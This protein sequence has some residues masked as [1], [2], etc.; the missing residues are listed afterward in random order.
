M[1][2]ALAVAAAPDRTAPDEAKP[3]PPADA[4]PRLTIRLAPADAPSARLDDLESITPVY[5]SDAP[6]PVARPASALASAAAPVPVGERVTLWVRNAAV[7]GASNVTNGFER[8]YQGKYINR[9]AELSVPFSTL[10]T[11]THTIQPGN[12]R[13]TA[14]AERRISTDDPEIVIA[15]SNMTVKVYAIDILA[16]RGDEGGPPESR[17]EPESFGLYVAPNPQTPEK[18]GANL[19]TRSGAFYS[20]R[21]YLPA[22][23]DGAGYILYPYGQT[24][25]VRPGGSVELTGDKLPGITTEGSRIV[26]EYSV[27]QGRVVTRTGLSA[28]LGGA[29]VRGNTFVLRPS[30][31]PLRFSAGQGLNSLAFGLPVDSDLT[32]RPRKYF[33]ADNTGER[34]AD[35]RIMA[36]E[37]DNDALTAGATAAVSVRFADNWCDFRMEDVVEPP[38][39]PAA[40]NAPAAD[41]ANETE[42]ATNGWR[43]ILTALQQHH[44]ASAPRHPFSEL[45]HRLDPQGDD[46]VEWGIW[47]PLP[48]TATPG[49]LNNIAKKRQRVLDA[50]SQALYDPGFYDAEGFAG[51]ALSAASRAAVARGIAKL[52]RDEMLRANRGLI[53]DL[54]PGAFRPFERTLSVRQPAVQAAWSVCYPNLPSRRVWTPFEVREWLRDEG[55]LTFQVPDLPVGFYH[56]RFTVADGAE[57][58]GLSAELPVAI[59]RA[60]QTG[61]AAIVSPKARDAFVA[62]ETIRLDAVIRSADERRPSGRPSLVLK[63]PDGRK[64]KVPFADRGGVWCAQPL[65]LAGDATRH[66]PPGRYELS[67]A[68]LPAGVVAWPFAFDIVSPDPRSRFTIVKAHKYTGTI[69]GALGDSDR[70]AHS[71]AELGY[72]RIELSCRADR[73]TFSDRE[74]IAARDP[75][76]PPPAAAYQPSPRDRLLNACVR[77]G[78]QYADELLYYNDFHI[79]R[80]IDPYIRATQRWIARET[81]TMRHSPAFDGIY[82]YQEMYEW[83]KMGVMDAHTEL[84]PRTREEVAAAKLG[85]RPADIRNRM[86]R[87]MRRPRV[88]RDPRVMSRFLELRQF[89][90]AGWGDF[91]S[92]VA[93]AVREVLPR[94]RVSTYNQAF[95][96]VTAGLGAVSSGVDMDCGYRPDVF[97]DLDIRNI[98]HY[99]DGPCGGWIHSP[100]LV[101][102]LRYEP[103]RPVWINYPV[104]VSHNMPMPRDGQYERRMAFAF[105]AEGA[106]GV[107]LWGLEHSLGDGPNPSMMDGKEMTAP[108]NREVLEPFG[109][110]ATATE[111][112]YRKVG[113][114]LTENQMIMSDFKE[115]RTA[116]QVEE[117][118]VACWRL[119]YPAVFLREEALER[120]LD[121]LDVIFVPGIRF[122]G[123]LSAQALQRLSD[124]V[125]RGAHVV[126]ERN[127][128]LAVPGAERIEFDLNNYFLGPG[129]NPGLWE[130]EV[131]RLF[132]YT[133]PTVDFLAA[134]LPKWTQP[135][136]RGPFTVGPNWRRGGDIHY[137]IMGNYELPDYSAALKQVMARPVRL[138][139]TVGAERGQAAYDLLHGTPLPI[140]KDGGGNR[141]TLDMTRIQ[142]ALAAFLPEPV[143]GLKTEVALAAD[144]ALIRVGGTLVGASGKDISGP[145]PARIT[146]AADGCRTG[147][148][149]RVLGGGRTAELQLPGRADAMTWRVEVREAL[150]GLTATQSI[151]RPPAPAPALRT[152]ALDRAYVPY[153]FEVAHFWRESREV[154]L[155]TGQRTPGM[156]AVADW[157]AAELGKRGIQ[158][159]RKPERA[160]YRHIGAGSGGMKGDPGADGLHTWGGY[161]EAQKPIAPLLTV[162]A[163][164]VLL[165]AAGGSVLLQA[166]EESRYL[167]LPTLGAPGLVTQPTVQRAYRAFHPDHDVLC[168]IAN[169]PEGMRRAAEA[170]L[171]AASEPPPAAPPPAAYAPPQKAEAAGRLPAPPP[172]ARLGNNERVTD[173]RFDAAGNG[174]ATTWGHGD[175]LYSLAPDGTVRFSHYLPELGPYAIAD[176]AEAVVA[177]GGNYE[178]SRLLPGF[179][180]GVFEDRIV[181]CTAVGARLYQ[182]GLDGKPLWQLR[183]A[184]DTGEGEERTPYWPVF[185]YARPTRLVVY[186]DDLNGAMRVI[187][188][189]GALAA[190]WQ[191]EPYEDPLDPT[192]GRRRK[193]HSFA[194]SP[195]GKRVAVIESTQYKIRDS[196]AFDSYLV[197]RGLIG[198]EAGIPLAAWPEALAN[199]S[200]GVSVS[201]QWRREDPGPSVMAGD[202]LVR[203][204]AGL[205]RVIGHEPLLDLA[206]VFDLGTN[207]ALQ[208]AETGFLRWVGR[209]GRERARLGPFDVMPSLAELSPDAKV[210][211]FLDEYGQAS[212]HDAATGKRRCAFTVPEMGHVA[213]F[214]PGGGTMLLGGL[215]GS[216]QAYNFDGK[217]LWRRNLAEHN[218]T[219]AA[220]LPLEKPVGF[221]RTPPPPT[222]VFPDLTEKQWPSLVDEPGQLEKLVTLDTDRLVNGDASGASGWTAEGGV[223]YAAEGFGDP[224]SLRVGNVMVSQEVS[225]FIGDHFTWLLEFRY[226]RAP[227][228]E[229][230]GAPAR[231]MA[232]LRAK[233]LQPATVVRHFDADDTWRFARIVTK[234][235]ADAEALSVGF[236]GEGGEI[237]VDAVSL[238]R[239]RFPSVNHMLHPPVYDVT[240]QIL[241]SPRFMDTYNPLGRLRE[242]IPNRIIVE[243]L[244]TISQ[245][246][247]EAAF[248]QNGRLN[249]VGSD[250]YIYPKGA[251]VDIGVGLREPHWISMVALYFNAYDEENITPHYDIIVTDLIAK[252]SRLVASVRNNRQLF[253]LTTFKPL[254]ADAITV[255]LINAPGRQRTVTEIEVYG[256]PSGQEGVARFLDADGQ[257]TYMG[258]FTRVD[259]RTLVLGRDF[260]NTRQGLWETAGAIETGG[261]GAYGDKVKQLGPEIIPIWNYP[262]VQPLVA[263]NRLY[264]PRGLG[265]VQSHSLTQG[266]NAGFARANSLGFASPGAVYGGVWLLPGNDGVLYGA[267]PASGRTLWSVPLGERL[268]GA[269]VAIGNDVFMASDTGRLCA[270]D[271]GSGALLREAFL[272]AGAVGSLA[273]DNANL[274]FLTEDGQLQCW[275]AASLRKRWTVPVAPWS[276]STPAIDGGI[277][278]TADR[279]GTAR[280]VRLTDGSIL[281]QRDLK[282]E[283]TRCPVVDDASVYLGFRRG[284]LAALNRAD[285]GVRWET[286]IQT[287][288]TYEPLPVALEGDETGA[289][290]RLA[291]LVSD[292]D[293]ATLVDRADG[294]R[295]PWEVRIREKDTVKTEGV[296][297]HDLPD[298]LSYYRG[299]LYR[300]VRAESDR[301]KDLAQGGML[302]QHQTGGALRIMPAQEVK[303]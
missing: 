290:R 263:D 116:N 14:S 147:L 62:G 88:D 85:E 49:E 96:Q 112:G 261:P 266:V 166:L 280:A 237:L 172:A 24:F 144:R 227:G 56:V 204:D 294:S 122:D 165:T 60:G 47:K 277:V 160:V 22:N 208:R 203:F 223:K 248:L 235:G 7:I 4:G 42:A 250:W 133:Q 135:A 222:R 48:S 180:L 53:T 69:G 199:E 5:A 134:L 103:R 167:S 299:A 177:T 29:L 151:W 296:E 171:P 92:R 169:D 37:W 247:L 270:V 54:F 12:H 110:L 8:Y 300:I 138:P 9:A 83:G 164:V 34:P 173:I 293:R 202:T 65:E 229:T 288:F 212:F 90:I 16:A 195:D 78:L 240:P 15:G 197:I 257:N 192:A 268:R 125:K 86:G 254:L 57:P 262:V 273:A 219:L 10:G 43:I 143:G 50:L 77:E 236:R 194:I 105:L 127:S 175:N 225:G 183:L 228:G 52:S 148:F 150:T 31:R 251:K 117:L 217:L 206:A 243:N 113:I 87:E 51:I 109:E 13:F 104:R 168:L 224:R 289:V 292:A 196:E 63:Q 278:Y 139:L 129:Y 252:Q 193:F 18:P 137:L 190:T 61:S 70:A 142:G 82:I 201:V 2:V 59:L 91:N 214:A 74:G 271:L 255:R 72:N 162:D 119:G 210:L 267:N 181:A 216:V 265:Y 200:G 297:L 41:A 269:P 298:S 38:A 215:R 111:P 179:E 68:D 264:L 226:R 283:F 191:G 97:R 232:G 36:L 205:T 99:Q 157:L 209:D 260:Q 55:T 284:K 79:P 120:P 186:R 84:W 45:L 98:I 115:L 19:L 159:T 207:G 27:F 81:A 76:L 246:M 256:P 95:L 303:P 176:G 155:V 89:E 158:V 230:G 121:G 241:T 156:D 187:D 211:F 281:W 149:Y 107:S 282:E 17:L 3:A 291:L 174:Y 188:E 114:V 153:P 32:R 46:K 58:T 94:A 220:L 140:E 100:M 66:L 276:E 279:L 146:L 141:V 40:T 33:V 154:L 275:D 152:L 170:A 242:A 67:F 71:L 20:L 123:E 145:F 213:R 185:R 106:D 178:E 258:D 6:A 287:R 163:P 182:I 198:A 128:T 285:G 73:H 136:A 131:Y 30:H 286:N 75:R 21:V 93:G 234:S 272:S 126:I 118:W 238:R 23:T 253:H 245:N 26:A 80:Y 124:A 64:E 221:P 28:G 302:H 239:I 295:R 108:L 244:P 25:H 130:D 259:R 35:V 189:H 233:N 101:Q 218:R 301:H 44:S 184:R 1:A 11:G 249:D 102:L 274:V 132:R 231:L 39:I 161:G